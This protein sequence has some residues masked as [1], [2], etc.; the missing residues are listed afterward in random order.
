[1]I[2]GLKGATQEFQL[3]MVL[4]LTFQSESL[5]CQQTSKI[6]AKEKQKDLVFL[7]YDYNQLGLMC[8]FSSNSE[9]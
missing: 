6:K 4:T 8:G 2:F 3:R 5:T 7:F 9:L 1:V